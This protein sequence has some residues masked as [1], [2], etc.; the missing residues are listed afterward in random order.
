M[1]GTSARRGRGKAPRKMISVVPKV[2]IEKNWKESKEKEIEKIR[3]MMRFKAMIDLQQEAIQELIKKR[4]SHGADSIEEKEKASKCMDPITGRIM[5]N[6]GSCNDYKGFVDYY[7]SSRM[8]EKEL[9]IEEK[10][11]KIE[12]DIAL[13]GP[14]IDLRVVEGPIERERANNNDDLIKFPTGQEAR[15]EELKN[16]FGGRGSRKRYTR[17]GS[18]RTRK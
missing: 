10:L 18:R 13:S 6:T 2:N 1:P 8:S 15:E 7:L 5:F 16:L 14:L 11:T 12:E 9:E 4:V 3:Y 17:K